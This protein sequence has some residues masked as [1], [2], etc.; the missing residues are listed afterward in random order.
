MFATN[1]LMRMKGSSRLW[2]EGLGLG[3][4]LGARAGG[5]GA[6]WADGGTFCRSPRWPGTRFD[7]VNEI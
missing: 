2:W 6:P 1:K 3:L 4:G 7:R 5:S